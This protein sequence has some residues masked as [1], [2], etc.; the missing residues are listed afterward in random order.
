LEKASREIN[1]DK[2]VDRRIYDYMN[3][4]MLQTI[5]ENKDVWRRFRLP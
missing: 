5:I 2:E 4:N 1:N 3:S